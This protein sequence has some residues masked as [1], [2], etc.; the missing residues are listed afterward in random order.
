M[1]RE[2]ENIRVLLQQ[3]C[4]VLK[5]TGLKASYFIAHAIFHYL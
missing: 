4:G 5:H 1:K 3:T 2:N